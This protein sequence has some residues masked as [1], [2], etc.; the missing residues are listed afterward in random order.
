LA[1]KLV[2]QIPCFNEEATLP[3][4]LACL[5]K[6]VDGFDAVEWLIVDDGS[7]DATVEVAKANGVHHVVRLPENR[8]LA[9][10]FM[11]GLD[12][13]LEC[14]ADVIVNTDA[15]NQY[16][17]SC[18]PE[19]V[20]PILAG[21]ADMVIGKRP[22]EFIDD[23]SPFKKLAQRVGSWVVRKA[24]NTR[25]PDAPSGFRAYSRDAAM[26]LQ[27]FSE[28]TYTLETIIQAGH[29]GMFVTSVPIRTNPRTRDSKL[30]RSTLGYI[31]RSF[32]TIVRIFITYQPFK[33]FFVPG[34]V[35]LLAGVGIGVR[36]LVYF[37]SGHGEGKVQS[38]LLATMLILIGLFLWV[39]A[40]VADLISVNRRLLEENNRRLRKLEDKLTPP[41]E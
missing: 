4:T 31:G 38:L 20:A 17:A 32:S 36:F 7:S 13:C 3:R 1:R 16:D 5:P 10:A 26:Q 39:I 35:S 28:Y 21:K 34:T 24:S 12:G 33:F 15:D 6:A 30:V 41:R 14:G 19:L 11:A 18:I 2:I 25:V 23:F 40:V 22:I 29:K 9:R 27:V 37:F 8:G